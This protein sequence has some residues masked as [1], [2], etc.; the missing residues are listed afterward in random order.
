MITDVVIAVATALTPLTVMGVA[1][2][3][4]V[5][6]RWKS[7]LSNDDW[8]MLHHLEK[9]SSGIW[10]PSIHIDLDSNEYDDT[11][12]PHSVQMSWRSVESLRTLV[13]KGF[14][15]EDRGSTSR[16]MSFR[17]TDKGRKFIRRNKEKLSRWYE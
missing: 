3:P 12:A 8:E 2:A 16:K 14:L 7:R 17:I 10:F 4:S 11:Q 1:V 5:W 13:E 15:E 9:Q 6:R